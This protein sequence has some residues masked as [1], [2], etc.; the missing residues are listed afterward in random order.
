MT[1][2]PSILDQSKNYTGKDFV[3][4]GNGAS[5]PITHTDTISPVLNI[6]LLEL[7]NRKGGDNR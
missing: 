3:I 4:V 2:D 1:A 7:S 5:L 6:H